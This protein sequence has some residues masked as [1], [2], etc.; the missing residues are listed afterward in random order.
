MIPLQSKNS[1]CLCG[2]GKKYKRCCQSSHDSDI[3]PLAERQRFNSLFQESMRSSENWDDMVE[4]FGE[5]KIDEV[6]NRIHKQSYL[7]DSNCD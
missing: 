6:L 3:P 1:R 7:M 4:E 5:E 2:S